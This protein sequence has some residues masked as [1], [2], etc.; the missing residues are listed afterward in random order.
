MLIF[1]VVF[2][3]FDVRHLLFEEK[4]QDMSLQSTNQSNA[5]VGDILTYNNMTPNH[6]YN[7]YK[8]VHFLTV[9]IEAPNN[10]YKT[11]SPSRAHAFVTTTRLC[12]AFKYEIEYFYAFTIR[13]T[14]Y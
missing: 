4:Q 9:F 14:C 13:N 6:R 7:N 12:V 8:I 10:H 11:F 5:I 1:P 3:F 2:L